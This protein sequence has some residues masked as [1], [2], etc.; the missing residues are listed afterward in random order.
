MKSYK[1]IINGEKY[2]AQVLEYSGTHA[3][4]NVNGNDFMIEIEDDN[5]IN[6]PKL[7]L[8]EKAVPIA[9]SLSSGIDLKSG[10]VKAPLPGVIVSI[11]VKEGDQVKHGQTI[12]VLEAMKMESEISAPVDGRIIRISVKER[13]LVQEGDLLFTLEITGD[14]SEPLPSKKIE[15]IVP[16]EIKAPTM[17]MEPI[18]R[19]PLPGVIMDVLVKP[20]ELVTEDTV[21]LVL[22]AMKMES[23]I[24]ANM[25]GK[26][27]CIHVQKGSSVNEGDALIVLERRQ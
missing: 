25:S 2:E 14:E 21:V 7:A 9:P 1:L 8:Q 27:Q 16:V 17:A 6:I 5:R 23:D 11:K 22:E 3:K 13:S 26:V 19:A 15:K 18:I 12:L 4:I 20:G 24:R 10:E